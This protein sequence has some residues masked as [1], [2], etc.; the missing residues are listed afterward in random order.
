MRLE[1]ATDYLLQGR[2]SYGIGNRPSKGY[3]NVIPS[4]TKGHLGEYVIPDA[5]LKQLEVGPIVGLSF[6]VYMYTK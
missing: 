4:T 6:I 2:I 5:R 1:P 3:V